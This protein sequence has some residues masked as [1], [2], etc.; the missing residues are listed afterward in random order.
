MKYLSQCCILFSFALVGELL[1]RLVP[2]PIPASVYGLVLLFAA[3][4][5]KIVRLEQVKETGDFLRS[6]LPLL[7][8]SPTVGIMEHWGLIAPR[9]GAIALLL[10]VSTFVT[11]GISGTVTRLLSGKGGASHG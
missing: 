7:F 6:L 3:L 9:L 4:C 11:F 8:V 5:L 2:L 1:Q 10:A